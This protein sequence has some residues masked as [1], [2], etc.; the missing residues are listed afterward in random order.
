MVLLKLYKISNNYNLEIRMFIDNSIY[1]DSDI[2]KYLNK[3]NNITLILY[4]CNN[5][6]INN[7]Y[8]VGLFDTLVRFFPLFNFKNNDY[9]IVYITDTDIKE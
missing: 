2:M 8:H 6:I 5:F 9:N 7:N 4:K 1:E 3:F